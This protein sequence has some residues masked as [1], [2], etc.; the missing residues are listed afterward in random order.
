V[1]NLALT[2]IHACSRKSNNL[3]AVVSAKRT[4]FIFTN[5]FYEASFE[6]NRVGSLYH[7]SIV[8]KSLFPLSHCHHYP[9]AFSTE[10]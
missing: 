9:G 8:S 5:I 1:N 10:D 6:R 2:G 3:S 7:D 4:L